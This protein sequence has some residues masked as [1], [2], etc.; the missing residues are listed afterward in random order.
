MENF[1]ILDIQYEVYS[2]LTVFE[3]TDIIPKELLDY[4]KF[5]RSSN[6]KRIDINFVA[7]EKNDYV[8]LFKYLNKSDSRVLYLIDLAMVN[9]NWKITDYLLS[10]GRRCLETP[11]V[12]HLMIH[13][14]IDLLRK[15]HKNDHD[16][17]KMDI[18]IYSSFMKHEPLIYKYYSKVEDKIA[19]K[20]EILDF[21]KSEIHT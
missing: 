2:F 19:N 16:Y 20:K 5:Y 1:L 10:I 18:C 3:Y 12:Q 15:D 11:T 17:G 4:D 13:N 21:I 9:N 7:K 14:K 8:E 6:Q